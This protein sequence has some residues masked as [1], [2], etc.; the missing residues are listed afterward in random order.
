M[1]AQL[2]PAVT[3]E[4]ILGLPAEAYQV[5]ELGVASSGVLGRLRHK[6]P[7]HIK[8]WAES[9]DEADTPAKVFGKAYHCAVL[10]PEVFA[11][12]YAKPPVNPPRDLR[13]LRN[14]KTP[15]DSTL[16]SIAW[17]DSYAAENAG[18][19]ILT[20]DQFELIEEMLASLKANPLVNK[21]LFQ[22]EGDNEVTMRWTDPETG[23]QC[24][25]RPDRWLRKLKV[26]LDL[27]SSDDLD[28]L[29]FRRSIEKYGYHIQHAHYCAGAQVCG[30]PLDEYLLI[31]QE[32]EAPYLPRIFRVGAASEE[33]GFELRAKGLKT[34]QQCIAAN[35]W[36]GYSG[37]TEIELAPWALKD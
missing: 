16:E 9:K 34:L 33:R 20:Q 37:I 2:K 35:K 8:A 15:S 22:D 27:K 11:A 1:N 30:E 36:P 5:R 24:K 21:L 28:E 13:H 23:V 4:I 26:M 3:G 19:I 17:W 12:T 7:A 32:K 29:A 6:T 31:A 10:E 18:K 25:A 14:A